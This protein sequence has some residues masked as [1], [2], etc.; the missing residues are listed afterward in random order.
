MPTSYLGTGEAPG[1]P[2]SIQYL[3]RLFTRLRLFSLR[4]GRRVLIP[5]R[6]PHH[7]PSRLHLAA[8]SRSHLSSKLSSPCYP[9]LPIG[10]GKGR[11]ANLDRIHLSTQTSNLISTPPSHSAT[12]RK[13]GLPPSR[14]FQSFFPDTPFPRHPT[15]RDIDTVG[16]PPPQAAAR[17]TTTDR[18]PTCRDEA[19]GCGGRASGLAGSRPSQLWQP[20]SHA[21]RPP[22]VRG[23]E[24]Q[25][26]H[27]NLDRDRDRLFPG[28]LALGAAVLARLVVLV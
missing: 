27:G 7:L 17:K 9:S 4:S 1:Y 21:D 2:E 14:C 26:Y 8:P 25:Q 18:H 28:R 11:T 3:G 20:V 10:I 6:L 16:G 13:T 23:G 22:N 15:G 12:L 24:L 19:H 5:L